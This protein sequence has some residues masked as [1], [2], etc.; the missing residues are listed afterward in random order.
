MMQVRYSG[1]RPISPVVFN[2][3]PLHAL[4]S[5]SLFGLGDV[6]KQKVPVVASKT[7]PSSVLGTSWDIF[8]EGTVLAS[9]PSERTVRFAIDYV[10]QYYPYPPLRAEARFT[11]DGR[12]EIVEI[13]TGLSGAAA[14]APVSVA[15]EKISIP[16]ELHYGG[17]L[18]RSFNFTT[19]AFTEASVAYLA[20]WISSR[21]HWAGAELGYGLWKPRG[22]V[23]NFDVTTGRPSQIKVK[24]Q[25]STIAKA[26]AAK[27]AFV[28]T[29]GS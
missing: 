28:S 26:E 1:I 4:V 18:L 27:K 25:A 13:F 12:M 24:V 14:V 22:F 10:A 11:A 23:V 2:H 29:Y 20:G 17:D 8:Y 19:S 21:Y 15:E 5:T 7:K 9:L 6:V 16:V 3:D